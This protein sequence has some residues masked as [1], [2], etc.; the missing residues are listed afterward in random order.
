MRAAFVS[1]ELAADTQEEKPQP[2]E[3]GGE[4]AASHER[5]LQGRQPPT[6][7][8]PDAAA[9]RAAPSAAP[10]A[11][12]APAAAEHGSPAADPAASALRTQSHYVCDIATEGGFFP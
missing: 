3:E 8:P 5:I 10:D 12:P 9:C 1:E 6:R 11:G 7:Q 4:G 2:E